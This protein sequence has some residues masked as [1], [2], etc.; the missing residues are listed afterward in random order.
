[1]DGA[2]LG[3]LLLALT[4][5]LLSAGMILLS[6]VLGPK[7]VTPYKASPYECGVQPVGDARERF[8][9]KFYLVAILFVLFD[10]EIVFLWGWMAAFKDAGPEFMVFSY[11]EVAIYMAT[12]IVGYIYAI[13]VGA[14][15]WDEATSLSKGM[16][17]AGDEH[18][19]VIAGAAT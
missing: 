8:P 10:I 15:E 6:T 14:I 16:Q 3:L 13:R 7:K 1:M 5:G 19:P 2:Y 18:E 12:W 9:I 11:A 4:A 17:V